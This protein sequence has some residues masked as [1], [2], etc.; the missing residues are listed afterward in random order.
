MMIRIITGVFL[1]ACLFLYEGCSSGPVAAGSSGTGNAFVAGVVYDDAGNRA[2][3]KMVNLRSITIT[4]E[5]DSIIEDGTALSASDGSYRFDSLSAGNYALF[6]GDSAN[7]RSALMQKLILASDSASLTTDLVLTDEAV[8]RG[9]IVSPTPSDLKNMKIA[10]PGLGKSFFA[11][12]QG[13]YT[14][15][16]APRSAYDIAFISGSFADFLHVDISADLRDT[17]FVNDV[18]FAKTVSESQGVENYY[19]SSLNSSFTVVPVEAQAQALLFDDFESPL[20]GGVARNAIYSKLPSPGGTGSGRWV[21]RPN[22][23]GHVVSPAVFPANF[24][25][26]IVTDGSFHGKSLRIFI[27][28]N[29]GGPPTGGIGVDICTPR[30]YYDLSKM[31]EFSF[32]A[33]GSG[34]HRVVFHAD[35]VETGDGEFIYEFTIPP[36]WQRIS[37]KPADLVPVPGSQTEARGVT[38]QRA[39]RGVTSISF[40]ALTSDTLYMDDVY[41]FGIAASDITVTSPGNQ[42]P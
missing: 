10:V 33:K 15:P 39:S 22:A 30:V 13:N 14:I 6:C 38:W 31:T 29:T 7:R 3:G 41:M 35:T 19:P 18:L 2:S 9:R 20:V 24:D 32:Y 5:G 12:S 36:N 23:D 42:M 26:C 16:F 21:V 1:A 25:S 28:F 11:D 27:N 37:I 8:V 40:F 17:V 4:P 34:R